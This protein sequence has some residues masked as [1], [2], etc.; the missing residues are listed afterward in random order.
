MEPVPWVCVVRARVTAK[1]PR[2]Q[3]KAS[4]GADTKNAHPT[5]VVEWA[6]EKT[7][8]QVWEREERGGEK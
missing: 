4:A 7:P 1:K 2:E 5:K 8:R 3:A 6:P